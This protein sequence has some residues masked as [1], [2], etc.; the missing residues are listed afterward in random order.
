MQTCKTTNE[1]S[2][3]NLANLPQ[4]VFSVWGRYYLRTQLVY[5]CTSNEKDTFGEGFREQRWRDLLNVLLNISDSTDQIRNESPSGSYRTLFVTSH[6]IKH[7]TDFELI[8]PFKWPWD[9]IWNAPLLL[10]MQQ[11]RHRQWL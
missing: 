1:N 4:L 7:E 8:E 2:W 5:Y 10:N 9:H 3:M 6:Q 11:R